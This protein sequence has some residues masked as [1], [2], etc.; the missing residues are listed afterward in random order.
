MLHEIDL[1]CPVGGALISNACRYV[2]T[3]H[4]RAH[5]FALFGGN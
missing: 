5:F 1:V 2:F 4:Y 3:E